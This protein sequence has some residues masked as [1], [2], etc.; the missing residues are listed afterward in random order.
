[1]PEIKPILMIKEVLVT[2]NKWLSLFYDE[3]KFSDGTTGR[4]NRIVERGGDGIA[5]VA[6]NSKQQ[7]GLIRIYRYPVDEW[8]WEIPRGFG[9]NIDIIDEASRELF[10]ETGII[11]GKLNFLARL[12]PNTGIS[13]T[14]I[15]VFMA[16]ELTSNDNATDHSEAIESFSFFD[17]KTIDE[18]IHRGEIQDCISLSTLFLA[19]NTISDATLR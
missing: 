11:A 18:M 7:I 4:Y 2:K 3:V 5:I 17:P 10:E 19:R 1:M 9:E 12:F 8:L 16:T 15:N 6:V 14:A 13:S